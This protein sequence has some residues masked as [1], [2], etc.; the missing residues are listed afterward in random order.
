MPSII[1]QSLCNAV[2]RLGEMVDTQRQEI[3]GLQSEIDYLRSQL[4]FSKTR[5]NALINELEHYKILVSNLE[6]NQK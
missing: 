4:A 1:E 5:E 6:A 3:R 2:D